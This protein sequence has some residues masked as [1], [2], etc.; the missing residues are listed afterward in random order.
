[1]RGGGRWDG[2]R[3]KDFTVAQ[4][5]I[6]TLAIVQK[7]QKF[8]ENLPP[9]AVGTEVG[10]LSL[11]LL[12]SSWERSLRKGIKG[13]GNRV[14]YESLSYGLCTLHIKYRRVTTTPTHYRRYQQSPDT[15]PNPSAHGVYQSEVV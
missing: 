7:G 13:S 14:G 3:T 15:A 10:T 9:R 2:R 8:M 12:S 4:D 5:L 1:M 11:I 6:V